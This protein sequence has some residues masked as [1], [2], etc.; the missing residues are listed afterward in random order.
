M[1]RSKFAKGAWAKMVALYTASPSLSALRLELQDA[2]GADVVLA[3]L[4]GLADRAGL[5]PVAEDLDRLRQVATD[6][7]RNVV[8]PLRAVRR[9]QKRRIATDAE[10][11]LRERIKTVELEA[12]RAEFDRLLAALATLDRGDSDGGSAGRYLRDLCVPES[13]I[14]ALQTML[15]I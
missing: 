2:H 3:L 14:D 4:L 11:A 10:A 5:S 12:E 15:A 6:W 9:W 1:D 8:L 7:Q 13:R